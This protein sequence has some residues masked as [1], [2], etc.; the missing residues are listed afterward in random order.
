MTKTAAVRLASLK[1]TVPLK[2]EQ[3][4]RDLVP[5]DGP[6]GEPLLDLVLE[7]GL[8]V[9]ARLNGRNYRRMLKQVDDSGAEN[10]AVILQGTLK[11]PA[12]PGGTHFARGMV[13]SCVWG[14]F[15]RRAS[16]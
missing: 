8:T 11:P 1:V 15:R 5:P 14:F 2:P 10:V 6:P 16:P 4:P 9:R 3:L 12:E 7:G 13:K